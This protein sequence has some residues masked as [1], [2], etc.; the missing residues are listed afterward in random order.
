MKTE[1]QKIAK[2]YRRKYWK[3]TKADE[4]LT[5]HE[6]A[7]IATARAYA[8]PYRRKLRRLEREVDRMIKNAEHYARS[9]GQNYYECKKSKSPLAGSWFTDSIKNRAVASALQSVAAKMKEKQ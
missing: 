4:G 2:I 1:S 3:G 9:S 6:S 5:F 7:A 8:A